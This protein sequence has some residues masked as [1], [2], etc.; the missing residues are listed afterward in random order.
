MRQQLHSAKPRSVTQPRL[1]GGRPCLDFVN[2]LAWRGTE[3]P[4]EGLASYDDL[5]TWSARAGL[6]P[7]R[8]GTALRRRAAAH[9]ELAEA[10]LRRA[11]VLREALHRLFTGATARARDADL[12]AVNAELGRA[13]ARRCLVLTGD[14]FAWTRRQRN[15]GLD[16]MLWP[17]V[18]SA[19]E[20]L[21]ERPP[22][23]TPARV[24][25]CANAH[26]GALFY[27]TSRNRSRR[28][29]AM[30]DCGNRAKARR[31]YARTKVGGVTAADLRA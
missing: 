3:R 25:A 21:V 19:A 17:I 6:L 4:A 30:E 7:P 2:T 22:G 10:T 26:C 23:P 15:G 9:P 29:C 27:D 14:A 12:A 18:W 28:W 16:A 1:I 20:L 24:K 8:D 11:Y 5:A 31:H 13:P